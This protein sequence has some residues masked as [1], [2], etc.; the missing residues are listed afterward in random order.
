VVNYFKQGN[1]STGSTQHGK[2]A[3]RLSTSQYDLAQTVY[4][5]RDTWNTTDVEG[6]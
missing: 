2:F 1:I 3:D 6:Y 4:L 5:K